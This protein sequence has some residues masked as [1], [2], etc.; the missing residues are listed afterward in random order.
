MA[1]ITITIN[2]GNDDMQTGSDVAWALEQYAALVRADFQENPITDD[3]DHKI[4]DISG[5]TVGEAVF[6]PDRQFLT[7][8]IYLVR[9]ES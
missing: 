8:T 4:K 5:N 1:A 9:P 7:E 2:L 6:T 3:A